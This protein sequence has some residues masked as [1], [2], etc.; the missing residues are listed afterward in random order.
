MVT[1]VQRDN[2]VLREKASP[3]K[4]E[5]VN[6][7]A[8]KRII[9]DMKEALN[10]QDD[11]VAIAACQIG[12]PLRIFVVSK[13]VFELLDEDVKDAKDLVC[14]NPE[15]TKLSKDKKWVPEGCLSVRYL[16]GKIKR[17]NKATIKAIDESGKP[18]SYGGSGLLA[19]VFQHE[20]D[21]LEGILFTDSAK[22]IEDLPPKSK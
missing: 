7:P 2:P 19:Q 18:F 15:I 3:V 17:S 14:I 16:Y 9:K 4:P 13:K 10:S 8:F 5:E 6:T 1:I 21:H 22:E 12:V 11:G 20:M